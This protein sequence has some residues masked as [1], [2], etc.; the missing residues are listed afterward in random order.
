MSTLIFQLRQL[1]V[2]LWLRMSVV[3]GLTLPI[4]PVAAQS[5]N[6]LQLLAQAAV[7][8]QGIFVDQL[9]VNGTENPL[10]HLRVTNAPAF[11]QAVVL[12]RGQI[13]ATL[14]AQDADLPSGEWSGPDRVRVIRRT[15]LLKEAEVLEM[16]TAVLQRD[17]VRD[18][19]ELELQLAR[20]WPVTPVPDEA[21]ELKVIDAP[22]AG[23]S[24]NFIA[25]FEL[26]A[27]V[28]KVGRWQTSLKGKIWREIW[29]TAGPL[30]RG[31]L[32]GAADLV[33]ERRDVLAQPD[34]LVNL[35]GEEAPVE[36]VDNLAAGA[37]VYLRAIRPRPIM[38]RGDLVQAL[39]EDGAMSV[40]LKV[41]VLEEGAFGQA[42]RVRN[43]LTRRELRGKVQNEQTI[44][45]SL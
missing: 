26:H 9:V 12:T 1:T 36:L 2:G 5:T 21:L 29:V 24:P 39:I 35:P 16:L 4:F 27:G 22:V 38:H 18:R 14:K 8:S 33:R 3:A 20:P 30:K 6:T 34:F 10:L 40:S 42:I 25:R 7:D 13:L 31:Q 45:V 28:E 23:V 32:L 17:Y 43:P 11:G 44:L 19:G 41:E 15:G 37:P